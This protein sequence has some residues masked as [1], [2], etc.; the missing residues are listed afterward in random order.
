MN[1]TADNRPVAVERVDDQSIALQAMLGLDS[2]KQSARLA[3]LS[4]WPSPDFGRSG[5][6]ARNAGH[7]A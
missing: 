7:C 4:G 6:L 2:F 3:G 5:R 1:E